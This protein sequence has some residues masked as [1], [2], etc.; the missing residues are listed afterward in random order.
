LRVHGDQ[1]IRRTKREA[2]EDMM[3]AWKFISAETITSGWD[4]Y[5]EPAWENEADMAAKC[6]ET[7]I[8]L[9]GPGFLTFITERVISFPFLC[10]THIS[11][12]EDSS[13]C[14]VHSFIVT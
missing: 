6:P 11:R 4:I 8:L 1:T 7:H 5:E 12:K 13:W 9:P 3:H 14:I 2:V 10:H